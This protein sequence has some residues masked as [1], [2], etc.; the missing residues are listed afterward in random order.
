MCVPRSAQGTTDL[1]EAVHQL[2]ILRQRGEL[3][4]DAVAEMMGQYLSTASATSSAARSTASNR[5]QNVRPLVDDNRK[6]TK[7]CS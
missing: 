7:K 4:A 3:T 6:T 5:H 2:E 1:E